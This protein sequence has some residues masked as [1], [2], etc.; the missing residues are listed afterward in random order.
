M[1]ERL[2]TL[3]YVL[4]AILLL[5]LMAAQ[6]QR[7]ESTEA[8]TT[9]F[10]STTGSIWQGAVGVAGGLRQIGENYQ[11]IVGAREE[12]Q[13][14]MERI[15]RL[16]A[17][18]ARAAELVQENR[19]L[20]EMLALRG[21]PGFSQAVVARVVADLSSGPL[22]RAVRVDR[23]RR[24]GVLPG[25]IVVARGALAGRVNRLDDDW[26]E[27]LLVSDPESGVA[28]RHQ[29]DRFA[30]ILRGGNR[31][32]STFARLEYV[33]RDQAVAVGDAVVTSGLDGVYPPG[34]LVGY[35]RDM[36]GDSPLTWRIAVEVAVDVS[37]MEEVLLVPPTMKPRTRPAP[38]SARVQPAS[39]PGTVTAPT[40]G[41]AS[42][43][44]PGAASGPG[45]TTAP[46]T[47]AR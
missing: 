21:E 40:P 20:R 22:R 41:T 13:R 15:N 23:G 31:G 26:S 30:G 4:I 9:A 44:A 43:P 39:P 32:P 24:D 10:R 29:L 2:A 6:A 12:R 27:V 3:V 47:A 38:P 16:E 46:G 19:R 42:A 17:E 7:I 45:A 33:P 14:L 25:W 11:L 5:A 37:N 36:A 8:M 34:L 35:V 28:V 18:N 1:G